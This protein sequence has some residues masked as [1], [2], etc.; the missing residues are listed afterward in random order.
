MLT[1]QHDLVGT[2]LLKFTELTEE[3]LR[4]ALEIKAARPYF[5][6][7]EILLSKQWITLD[8]LGS[9]LD[10]QYHSLLLGQLLLKR[11]VVTGD[12]LARAL[13]AQATTGDRLGEVL[14]N[15]GLCTHDAI[16]DTLEYQ[17]RQAPHRYIFGVSIPG[18]HPEG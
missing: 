12:Q 2:L 7:G 15:L 10:V 14:V 8:E 16:V 6:I 13:D 3:Q 5:R 11:G 1:V 4:I 17:Q 9:A 18:P